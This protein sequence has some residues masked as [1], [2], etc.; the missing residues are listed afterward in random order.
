MSAEQARELIKSG[1]A[2]CVIVSE[3]EIIH[4]ANGRGVAP[5]LAVYRTAPEKLA[6]SYVFDKVIGKA[7]A[8]ILILGGARRAYGGVMSIAAREYLEAHGIPAEYGCLA[9]RIKNRSGDGICPIEQAVLDTACPEEC[10][11]RIEAAVR[12]LMAGKGG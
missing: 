4:T 2:S 3:N 5:L 12:T 7:A 1:S 11:A 8:V 6:G 10:F 9:E